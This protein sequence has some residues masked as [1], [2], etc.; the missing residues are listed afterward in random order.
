LAFAAALTGQDP[1]ADIWSD[2]C[3]AL[4][5]ANPD[6]FDDNLTDRCAAA[7]QAR[8]RE[9]LGMTSIEDE[10]AAGV[11]VYRVF[12]VDGYGRDMPTVSFERRPNEAPKVVIYGVEGRRRTSPVSMETWEMVT[13]RSRF[14]EAPPPSPP[15]PPSSP[16]AAASGEEIDE[17]VICLHSWVTTFEATMAHDGRSMIRRRTEDGCHGGLTMA[18]AF[19]AAALAVS[20]LPACERL[21]RDNHRNDVARLQACLILEGDSIAAAELFNEKD[22]RPRTLWNKPV[23]TEAWREWLGFGHAARIEWAGEAFAEPQGYYDSRPGRPDLPQFLVQ[24]ATVLSPFDVYP[25]RY[26]GE[27]ANRARI[28]GQMRYSIG[29]PETSR[30]YMVADYSQVWMR[31]RGD[32]WRLDFWTVGTFTRYDVPED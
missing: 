6:C 32:A 1:C 2:D 5:R 14:A 29:D 13:R 3:T 25:A 21:T 7:E 28:E 11:E 4:R 19:E 12:F 24:R 15:P 23:T 18:Y 26:I 20:S 10:A 27:S 17:V 9:L 8:V 16:R 22:D 31:T 30:S